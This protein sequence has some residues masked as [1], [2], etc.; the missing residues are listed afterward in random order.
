MPILS[1]IGQIVLGIAQI[2]TVWYKTN[3]NTSEPKLLVRVN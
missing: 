1:C 3:V 2:P